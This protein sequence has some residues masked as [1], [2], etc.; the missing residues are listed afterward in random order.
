ML[1]YPAL[2]CQVQNSPIICLAGRSQTIS[3]NEQIPRRNVPFICNITLFIFATMSTV[4]IIREGKVPS[5]NR[6]PLTP[7][8]CA[9]YMEAHPQTQIIVEWSAVRCYT[10]EDYTSMDVEVLENVDH[11]DLLLGIKEVPIDMLVPGKAYMFFSHTHKKQSYNRPLLQAMVNKHITMIDYELLTDENGTRLIGFGK[12]AGVIGAHYALLMYG[13]RT[14]EFSFKPAIRCVNL[15]EMTDQY[16]NFEFPHFKIAIT[17]GGRVA[18][19]AEEIMRIAGIPEISPE[20]YLAG[21]HSTLHPVFTV[22]R[23]EHLYRMPD[24]S[25]F[26]KQHFYAHPDQYLS[27]FARFIPQTDVLINCMYWDNNAPRLFE[28]KDVSEGDF[29]MRT[30]ADVSCDVNGSVPLTKKV[31]YSDAPVFG[32]HVDSGEIGKPYQANTIDVMAVTNL[33][34]E[35]PKDASRDFGRIILE[36]LIPEW[37]ATGGDNAVFERATICRGGALTER[38]S[39]LQDFIDGKE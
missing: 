26:D 37:E 38:F 25:R 39:Y 13:R 20:D 27:D 8:Q 11:A 7:K 32:Y 15:Q 28:E 6:T 36:H 5:D 24:N 34:N 1:T 17:G 9:E 33:P 16:E 12:W 22:L 35:L 29:R 30:I 21:N 4:A 10:D 19:G 23:S 14:G 2:S 31:T 18:H 3:T